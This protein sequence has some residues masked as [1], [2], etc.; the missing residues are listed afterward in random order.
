[1]DVGLFF[2]GENVIMAIILGPDQALE[3]FK[4]KKEKFIELQKSDI[5][6]ATTRFQILDEIFTE[7]L[8]WPKELIDVE[9]DI[10]DT[11]EDNT[12]KTI[13]A[14]YI[15]HGDHN[16]FIIEA[17]RTGSYFEI[18]SGRTRVLKSTSTIYNAQNKSYIDQAKKYMRKFG[19]AYCVLSNGF[20]FIII[21]RPS[22]RQNVDTIVFRNLDDI[23]IQFTMFWDILN[24]HADGPG[25]ID[26]VLKQQT[27]VRQPPS[28]NYKI[29][30]RI[31]ASD[32]YLLAKHR[33]ILNIEEFINRFFGELVS[34]HQLDLLQECYC[35]PMDNYKD[36][37]GV[38]RKRLAPPPLSAITVLRGREDFVTRGNFEKQYIENLQKVPGAVYVLLGEVGVGK[39]TFLEHFYN[40]ELTEI[41]KNKL[42]WIRMDFLKFKA[43]IDQANQF[44]SDEIIKRIESTEYEHL[45]LSSWEVK[46]LIYEKELSNLVSGLPPTLLKNQELLETKLWEETKIHHDNIEKR[47]SRTFEY[48]KNKKN[49]HVCLIFDNID[50][51]EFDEQREVLEISHQKAQLYGSTVITAMRYQSYNMI[52]NKPPYDALQTIEYRMQPPSAKEILDKR[53]EALKKYPQQSFIYEYRNK[54]IKIPVSKFVQILKNTLEKDPEFRVGSLIENLAGANI[55]RLLKIFRAMITSGNTRLHEILDFINEISNIDNTRL[56][57]DQ[58]FEGVAKDNNKY[59]QSDSSTILNLFEFQMDGFYSH[60]LTVYILKYLEKNYDDTSGRGFVDLGD[61]QVAFDSVVISHSNLEEILIPLL[62][63]FIINSDIG[64]RKDLMGTSSIRISET[65][66]YYL[67]ELL[68]N[69][70]YIFNIMVDTPI[71][72]QTQFTLIWNKFKRYQATEN[73]IKKDELAY[74]CVE[75]FLDYLEYCET[76]DLQFF[77]DSKLNLNGLIRNLRGQVKVSYENYLKSK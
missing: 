40:F 29:Y 44:I 15:A 23:E 43:P 12:H 45:K 70:K 37:A 74:N 8:G 50:Q 3:Q 56:T 63:N 6:E 68:P 46:Q 41:D 38:I 53:L 10:G 30:D 24:P 57:F 48:L 9:S 17:K 60:F 52:K 11:A 16:F 49:L 1:M 7:V 28:L 31:K 71:R 18:P 34:E 69:W 77:R 5:N 21:R 65:G 4:Q 76:E 58:V 66:R 64:G 47:I 13:F 72:D 32:K 42:V 51:K 25:A 19:T 27:E 62:N 35:D 36:F 67:D 61:L 39:S 54:T 14:D 75:L 55:R 59:Y 33:S 20:Q 73:R 22:Q 26:R 2:G